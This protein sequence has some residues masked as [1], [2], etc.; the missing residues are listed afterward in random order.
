MSKIKSNIKNPTIIV[1]TL[2]NKYPYSFKILN[3]KIDDISIAT[4]FKKLENS[5]IIL[6]SKLFGMIKKLSLFH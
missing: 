6:V 3:K 4:I 1:S 2:G 5:Q